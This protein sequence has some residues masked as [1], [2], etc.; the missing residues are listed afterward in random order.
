MHVCMYVF[1]YVCGVYA[2]HARTY[3]RTYVLQHNLTPKVHQQLC[4]TTTRT[5]TG[6]RQTLMTDHHH[7]TWYHVTCRPCALVSDAPAQDCTL[8]LHLRL[9]MQPALPLPT[10]T[11]SPPFTGSS[12]GRRSCCRTSG[13]ATRARLP[14]RFRQPNLVAQVALARLAHRGS[15][16][17]TDTR[18]LAS[19]RAETVCLHC[20]RLH[21]TTDS[22]P[23]PP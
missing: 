4:T 18:P 20:P 12:T 16:L 3:V 5:T 9:R 6:N 1:M 8:C 23:A 7:Q 10:A 21:P 15:T 17:C 2:T 19:T 13:V 14:V 11:P 22:M